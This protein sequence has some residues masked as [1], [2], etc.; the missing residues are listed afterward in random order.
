M[1]TRRQSSKVIWIRSGWLRG[2]DWNTALTRRDLRIES[3]ER[4]ISL[5][6]VDERMHI[7]VWT[8]RGPYTRIISMRKANDRRSPYM[9]R[10]KVDILIT[11]AGDRI[12]MPTAEESKAIDEQIASDPNDFELDDAWFESA[13]PTQ[14]LFPEAYERAVRQKEALN[15]GLIQRVTVTLDQETVAWFRAQTGEDGETSGTRWLELVAQTLRDHA[16]ARAA[17]KLPSPPSGD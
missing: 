5:G 10:Q 8:P 4:W 14:E 6:P 11:D 15:A 12:I 13:K 16:R 3:E 7:V 1:A 17:R 2:S 9:R